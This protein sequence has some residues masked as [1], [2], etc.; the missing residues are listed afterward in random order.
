VNITRLLEPVMALGVSSDGTAIL[1]TAVV[2]NR[3]LVAGSEIHNLRSPLDPPSPRTEFTP[4]FSRD[5]GGLFILGGRDQQTQA[6]L[7]DAWFQPVNGDW[8]ELVFPGYSP[9]DFLAATYSF[10]DLRRWVLDHLVDPDEGDVARLVRADP[11]NGAVEVVGSWRAKGHFDHWF[12]S[13]DR[14][15]S[16]LLAASSSEKRKHVTVRFALEGAHPAPNA[17]LAIHAKRALALAPIVD[18]RSYAFVVRDKDNSL[19]ICRRMDLCSEDD[20]EQGSCGSNHGH[21]DSNED[22]DDASCQNEDLHQACEVSCE[23]DSDAVGALLHTL[24]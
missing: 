21:G 24:F 17:A 4:V 19:R 7:H 13:I 1:D 6:P 2:S 10:R 5:A 9:G 12:L 16:V 15:G 11:R 23:D 8:T 22:Q 18:D 20:S 3:I 14:D